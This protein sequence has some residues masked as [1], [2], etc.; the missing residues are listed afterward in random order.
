MTITDAVA[1]VDYILGNK[2]ENFDETAADVNNDGNVNI[3][4]AVAIV[5]IILNAKE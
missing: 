2:P 1:V 5:D 3:T 4:D